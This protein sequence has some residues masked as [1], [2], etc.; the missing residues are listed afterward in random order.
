MKIL[1]TN[2]LVYIDGATEAPQRNSWTLNVTREL[3]EARVFS[4]TGAGSH[5]R[6]RAKSRKRSIRLSASRVSSSRAS[7]RSLDKPSMFKYF[8][9]NVA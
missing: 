2:A 3:H 7:V 5:L 9:N 1:G 4:D 8:F 6:G